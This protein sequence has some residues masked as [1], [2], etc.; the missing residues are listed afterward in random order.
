MTMT[1]ASSNQPFEKSLTELYLDVQ[2]RPDGKDCIYYMKGNAY[3]FVAGTR[4]QKLMGFEGYNIRRRVETPE[5]DGFFVATR[6]LVFYTDPQ[7]GEI[8]SQWPNPFTNQTNEVFH[9]TNDPVNF[10]MRRK[11]DSY[12]TVSMDGSREFGEPTKPTE[13]EDFYVWGADIFPFYPLPGWE[14]NYTA[15][16]IFDFYVPK[17]ARY[18]SEPPMVLNTWVRI[19]PWLPWLGM[20][21]QEGNMVY[22]A[23]VKRFESWDALPDH[24]QSTVREKYPTYMSAPDTVDPTQP[25]DTSWTVYYAEMK[26]RAMSEQA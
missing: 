24:I 7:S 11:G 4:P 13:W 3:S 1:Q 10:R 9:I 20:D 2:T 15:S 25:N 18:S 5:K 19:G 23:H 26:R 14:K 8:I 21:G 17:A 6:E 16:E 22:H 12:V